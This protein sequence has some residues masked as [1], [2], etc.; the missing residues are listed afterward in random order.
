MHPAENDLIECFLYLAYNPVF[1]TQLLPTDVY[2]GSNEDKWATKMY[3]EL[4][5][6]NNTNSQG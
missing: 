2:H 4:E 1:P 3:C 6:S 5:N